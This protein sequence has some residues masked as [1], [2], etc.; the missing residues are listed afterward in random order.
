MRMKN[1]NI[2]AAQFTILTAHS[3]VTLAHININLVLLMFLNQLLPNQVHKITKKT[4]PK[5]QRR[6]KKKFIPFLFIPVIA[7]YPYGYT[8][9]G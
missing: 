3:T 8:V 1:I 6:A 4:N 5:L 9:V 2:T 7:G